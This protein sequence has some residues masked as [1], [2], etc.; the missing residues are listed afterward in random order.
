MHSSW[1]E[2]PIS[3]PYPFRWFTPLTIV[4]GIVLAVVFTL[5]NLGSSGFYLQSEFTSD[6]NKT[7]A[8]ETQWFMKP[9]FSWE[10][11]IEPK[12]EAKML[13]V[14]DSFFTSALGF[15]YTV[16]SLESFNDSDP[17]SVTTFP[18]IPYMKNTLE[19]CYLDR[20]S[21][22]LKK[23]DAVGSP[24]WWISW[25]SAS[26]VDAT[27]ACSVMTQHGRV[28]VS[29][30]LQYTGITDHL[31]GYILEDNPRTNASIWWG[32]R[33]LNAY[34]AGA[35]EIMSLTQQVSDEKDDHYWAFGN[36]PYWRN[37]S[38]QDIRSL[39]FFSSDAWIAS[40]R[41][42]IANT[43]TK[44]FTYLFENPKHPVSPV[45]TEGLHYAKILHSLVS[46]DLGN[47][48]APNLLLNDDDLKY[49][50][51]APDSPN[52]K[53][54]EK[55]DYSNGTYYADMAR[56]SKIPR[57]YTIYNRNLTFLNE[58][59]DEFRPLTGKLGCKNSTIVAQ[60]L[61]SV[62]RS[63]STGTMILA[64][65]LANLCSWYDDG[66]QKLE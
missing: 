32:T 17:K 19:D 26:S 46:I 37:L 9:P 59:Y 36:I 56:Y 55:L 61:C 31:Y 22:K 24:T 14:G 54:N 58:A 34:L 27:A 45:A 43:N 15:Q 65:V 40:S 30:A 29:L 10:H 47:C 4:G 66:K 63:K 11:N 35:W 16:K 64:I 3:R 48:Q 21:L 38:Q 42:W 12:C 18:T 53:S 39:D 8:G 1:F 5:I 44:N 49:A 6:P 7:V 28:N 41:G 50:I 23:S 57:P 60:Y 51:N 52:R 2:Y 20:V 13:S 25:S 33:L 62:P